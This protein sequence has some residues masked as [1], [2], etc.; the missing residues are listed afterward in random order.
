MT[1]RRQCANDCYQEYEDCLF[2]KNKLSIS[3]WNI[4][5]DFVFPTFTNCLDQDL[6]SHIFIFFSEIRQCH[7][8][9]SNHATSQMIKRTI[10]DIY[11][12]FFELFASDFF[13]TWT[14]Y[15]I[16][17]ETSPYFRLKWKH[18]FLMRCFL[19]NDDTIEIQFY[20][21][22]QTIW[23]TNEIQTK[24]N[25]CLRIFLNDIDNFVVYLKL[26]WQSQ[27]NF[28]YKS[29]FNPDVFHSLHNESISSF[30]KKAISFEEFLLWEYCL[31]RIFS[32]FQ[33]QKYL[34]ENTRTDSN[35]LLHV[36]I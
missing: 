14:K 28:I 4:I 16:Q 5:T 9:H 21:H 29:T 8:R 23:H 32:P 33:I 18:C 35:T 7:F 17:E 22:K 24:I 19:C 27:L 36:F 31:L 13:N 30:T 25:E 34:L 12:R 6:L 3:N 1:K 11:P 20:Q 10:P 26:Y 15:L 2:F